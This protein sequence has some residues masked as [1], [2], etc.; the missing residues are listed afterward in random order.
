M[1]V[2]RIHTGKQHAWVRVAGVQGRRTVVCAGVWV[3]VGGWESALEAAHLILQI[4]PTC[5][6]AARHWDKLQVDKKGERQQAPRR[7][8]W[9]A[10]MSAH[11]W[12]DGQ[13]MQSAGQDDC[14]APNFS[15]RMAL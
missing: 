7:G 10:Q 11:A 1:R 4:H 14:S 8:R 9:G 3:G 6:C 2:L 12:V 5:A 15:A 13:G